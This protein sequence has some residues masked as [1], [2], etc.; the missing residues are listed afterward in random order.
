MKQEKTKQNKK[1]RFIAEPSKKNE[2]FVFKILRLH[3]G[4]WEKML[5]AKYEVKLQRM[6]FYSDW[7]Q[8]QNSCA[9][10]EVII[11]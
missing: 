7:L 2:W 4:L 11:L 5:Q 3:D 8:F 6:W 10:A 1:K 9:Q